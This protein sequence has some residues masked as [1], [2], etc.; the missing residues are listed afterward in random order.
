MAFLPSELIFDFGRILSRTP[1]SGEAVTYTGQLK[2]E[3][4]TDIRASGGF[5]PTILVFERVKIFRVIT[6]C[7]Y[8]VKT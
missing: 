7:L 3:T 8:D 4:R 6:G 2:Q 5:K 1:M